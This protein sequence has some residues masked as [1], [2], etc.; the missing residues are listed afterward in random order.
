MSETNSKNA[1]CAEKGFSEAL[2]GL[3]MSE[4]LLR[5]CGAELVIT[6]PQKKAF[7]E[8][9]K[10]LMAEIEKSVPKSDHGL[11]KGTVGASNIITYSNALMA[12][13][14]LALGPRRDAEKLLAK[15]EDEKIIPKGDHGL[16]GNGYNSKKEYVYANA[17]MA[18]AY[19]AAGRRQDAENLLIK[20]D[21]K[22]IMPRGKHGLFCEGSEDKDECTY[23]NTPMVLLYLA[24]G[25]RQ[26]AEALLKKVEKVIPKSTNGMF[27]N[28]PSITSNVT[29]Y[30]NAPM[31]LAY[32]ALGRRQDAEELLEKIEKAIPRGSHGLFGESSEDND[33]C[34]YDN[35]LMV[36]VYC[37]L[38]G[39]GAFGSV[40]P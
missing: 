40:M 17:A 33:E 5:A 38:A 29:I 25:R 10:T 23:C 37:A 24:L 14:Y 15:L 35:A 2:R 39:I 19:F 18:L 16:F 34:T 36:L 32:L 26:D 8:K 11:F 30:T 31:A 20:L 12:L 1:L 9:A 6:D 28:S 4:G 21:D 13:A 22:S 27:K 3:L 7:L